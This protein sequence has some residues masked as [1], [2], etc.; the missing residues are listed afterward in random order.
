M[1][2]Q[3]WWSEDLIEI[4]E[5]IS[6]SGLI[7]EILRTQGVWYFGNPKET[8]VGLFGHNVLNDSWVLNGQTPP[9]RL[10][11]PPQPNHSSGTL[12]ASFVE[13]EGLQLGA[14]L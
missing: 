11:L 7:V 1:P 2:L 13:K 4:V 8:L 14:S 5:R 9:P 12:L 3:S 10:L 6:L